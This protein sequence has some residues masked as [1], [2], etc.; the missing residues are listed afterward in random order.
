MSKQNKNKIKDLYFHF[1]FMIY[2]TFNKNFYEDLYIYN[3][4]K[5]AKCLQ[6]IIFVF[7]ERSLNKKFHKQVSTSL[8]DKTN[9]T[10]LI[11]LN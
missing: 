10:A 6:A 1:V 2:L 4:L 11:N 8:C 7:L 3:F 9:V 5:A